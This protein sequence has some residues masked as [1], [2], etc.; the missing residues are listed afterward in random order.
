MAHHKTEKQLV[1][2]WLPRHVGSIVASQHEWL[3]SKS[4]GGVESNHSF[5]GLLGAG[6]FSASGGTFL[7]FWCQVGSLQVLLPHSKDMQVGR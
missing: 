3:D 6:E 1:L 4:A 7:F 2:S 5:G